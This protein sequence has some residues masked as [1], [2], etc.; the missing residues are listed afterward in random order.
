ME[1]T[2]DKETILIILTVTSI[3]FDIAKAIIEIVA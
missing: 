3:V 2:M 1:F